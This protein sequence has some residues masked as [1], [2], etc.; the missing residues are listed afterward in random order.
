MADAGGGGS[1]YAV[2]L[3]MM[4][5]GP[6]CSRQ[7]AAALVAA[8]A[9]FNL[10][11]AATIDIVVSERAAVYAETANI[12]R[13]ELG[14][15]ATVRILAVDEIPLANPKNASLTVTLGTRA[16][17]T[18]L[19]QS[20][21]PIVLGLAPRAAYENAI[22]TATPRA[23]GGVYLDQ[24][25]TRQ[26]NLVRV[27][28]GDKP[29]VGVLVGPDNERAIASLQKAARDLK[30]T[31]AHESVTAREEIYPMLARLLPE[32]DALLAVPD[33]TV[34]SSATIQNVLLTTYRAQRPVF[35]FSPAYVRAGALAAV[36][37]MPSDMAPQIAE[38]A[39]HILAG[40]AP[41]LQYPRRFS[42]SV[43]AQ[44]ARSLGLAVSEESTIIEQLQR[45]ER[46]P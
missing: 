17:Q 18:A 15:R 11:A 12:V 42:V 25:Y 14:A 27:V 9:S 22:R 10:A 28:L 45:M 38:I 21:S 3:P 1:P 34:Y 29:R 39:A 43:N 32:V 2:R 23:I 6:Y 26:L 46:E 13:D 20:R 33:A 40:G 36:H 44:V 24:P 16:L 8:A 37:S 4:P 7:V 19:A 31:L 41:S 5:T 35:G 30:M